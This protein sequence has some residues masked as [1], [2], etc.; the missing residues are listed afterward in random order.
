MLLNLTVFSLLFFHRSSKED[1]ESIES[2][3]LRLSESLC[4]LDENENSINKVK[5]NLTD[6]SP[7][8][9][10]LYISRYIDIVNSYGHNNHDMKN[11]IS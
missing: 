9:R 7:P 6:I 10:F 4:S 3:A 5:H 1:R 11:L 8:P 2:H